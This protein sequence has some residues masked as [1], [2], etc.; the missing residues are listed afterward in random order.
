MKNR[1]LSESTLKDKKINDL[2]IRSHENKCDLDVLRNQI[3]LLENNIK[4]IKNRYETKKITKL[5]YIYD[6]FEK[7]MESTDLF[8][9]IDKLSIEFEAIDLGRIVSCFPNIFMLTIKTKQNMSTIKETYSNIININFFEGFNNNI[10]GLDSNFPNLINIYFS[11]K[12]NRNINCLKNLN[13]LSDLHFGQQFNQEIDS[14]SNCTKLMKIN[15]GYFFNKSINALKNCVNLVELI[16]G[17]TFNQTIDMLAGLT[18]L[19]KLHLGNNFDQPI[20]SLKNMTKLE[21]LYIGHSFSKSIDILLETNYP[22]MS[23]LSL[24]MKNITSDKIYCMN[25][26]L[27]LKKLCV[28]EKN[29]DDIRKNNNNAFDVSHLRRLWF[30]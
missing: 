25:N 7:K 30:L 5:V 3:A 11:D 20:K 4:I 9:D 6:D 16:L 12:F 23:T 29:I 1:R 22:E 17:D 28:Y 13:K 8:P 26:M 15:F 2:Y 21:T 14:L 10:D 19:K 27:K 18:N 24:C